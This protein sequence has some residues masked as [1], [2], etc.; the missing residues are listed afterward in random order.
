MIPYGKAAAVFAN[1]IIILMLSLSLAYTH[2]NKY[3]SLPL[4]VV[5]SVTLAGMVAIIGLAI[6]EEPK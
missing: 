4:G 2:Q 3:P 6:V 1:S 5:M